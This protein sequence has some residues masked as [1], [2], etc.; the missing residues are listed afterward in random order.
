M[1]TSMRNVLPFALF[2]L[3]NIF[4]IAQQTDSYV[5]KSIVYEVNEQEKAE[6]QSL[7]YT[8]ENGGLRIQGYMY[9]NSCGIHVMNCLIANDQIYLSRTDIGEL[10]DSEANYKVDIFIDGVQEQSY[11]VSLSEYGCENDAY[12]YAKITAISTIFN[13]QISPKSP[14]DSDNIIYQYTLNEFAGNCSYSQQLDS[15]VDQTL[16]I[17]GK[18]DIGVNCV[19]PPTTLELPLGKLP[20]GNYKI[21]HC[22]RE[23]N[24]TVPDDIF[25]FTFSVSELTSS[26]ECSEDTSLRKVYDLKGNAVDRPTRGLYI[27]RG[28]KIWLRDE[29]EK[30]MISR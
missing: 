1:K 17:S 10:C 3:C 28:K 27:D 13:L 11:T 20:A 6:M 16:Y 7:T 21:R 24:G 8:L 5:L 29:M 30:E 2:L 26:I 23:M 14:T 9:I 4:S 25:H 15:I 12:D 22:V 18:Y 19:N